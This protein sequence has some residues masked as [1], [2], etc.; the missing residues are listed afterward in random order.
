MILPIGLFK[1][2]EI[3]FVLGFETLDGPAQLFLRDLAVEGGVDDFHK[4]FDLSCRNIQ[5]IVLHELVQIFAAN[6]LV[7]VAVDSGE[8]CS[9]GVVTGFGEFYA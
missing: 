3:G 5:L 8:Y 7:S 9:N 1:F 4:F 2:S 6:P